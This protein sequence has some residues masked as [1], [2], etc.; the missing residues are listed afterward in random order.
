MEDSRLGS[1]LGIGK[2]A[3]VFAFGDGA[4]KLFRHPEAKAAAFREA[5]TMAMVEQMGL[6][7]PRVRGVEQIAGRWAV[8]MDRAAG[9]TLAERMRDS[10]AVPEC[11]ELMV[12]LHQRIHSFPATRFSS[13]KSRLARN[14]GSA[15]ALDPAHR[16]RLLGGLA[17]MPD[18]NR[19]CH[20]DFH[21]MNIM[22]PAGSEVV[23]DWIDASAGDPA[24]DVCRSYVLI[25]PVS[26]TL[27]DTYADA[28][29]AMSG[30]GRA[31]IMAWLPYVAAARLAK[32]AMEDVPILLEMAGAR[33]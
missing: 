11:I 7:L 31:A 2:E 27:A 21:P 5:A 25:R 28:Y 9:P 19:L 1:L 6:P 22:G 3:E 4:A 15:P 30:I 14:I 16:D 26:P 29:A 24:A 33:R 12:L 18:G 13:L 20:G 32:G 10:A 8:V 17:E 23:L